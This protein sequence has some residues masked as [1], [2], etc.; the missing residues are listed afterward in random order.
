MYS[1]LGRVWDLIVKC[2]LGLVLYHFLPH[3]SPIIYKM[4]LKESN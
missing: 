4:E 2:R 1:G 3:P